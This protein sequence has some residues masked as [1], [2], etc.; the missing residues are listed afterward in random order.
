MARY[1]ICEAADRDVLCV[2]EAETAEAALRAALSTALGATL[3]ASYGNLSHVPAQAL[4]ITDAGSQ[5]AQAWGWQA[6]A[7]P[8]SNYHAPGIYLL[9]EPRW[10]LHPRKAEAVALG[11][12]EP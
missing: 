2:Q 5:E 10:R 11:D 4:R 3:R 12:W 9:R 1:A 8:V 7:V 6:Y